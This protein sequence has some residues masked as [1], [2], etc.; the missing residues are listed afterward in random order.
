LP[1]PQPIRGGARLRSCGH[2]G[3]DDCVTGHSS[4]DRVSR[5]SSPP[6][7]VSSNA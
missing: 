1:A 3:I 4:R 7:A 6:A 2:R 5:G